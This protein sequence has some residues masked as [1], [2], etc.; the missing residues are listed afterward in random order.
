MVLNFGQM[1][2]KNICVRMLMN[3]F[4][5]DFG[6]VFKFYNDGTFFLGF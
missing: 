2:K 1:F 3:S 5:N 6:I 4:S